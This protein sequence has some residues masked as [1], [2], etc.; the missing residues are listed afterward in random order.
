MSLRLL[1]AQQPIRTKKIIR[2][3]AATSG[4]EALVVQLLACMLARF[5][6][7]PEATAIVEGRKKELA[8]QDGEYDFPELAERDASARAW[9][10]TADT[11]KI[12]QQTQLRFIVD[13]I[14]IS[15]NGRANT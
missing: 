4:H 8:E 15:V 6:P 3:L 10:K 12:K 14:S 2:A 13:N 11:V 7:A 5:W 1:K 9:L